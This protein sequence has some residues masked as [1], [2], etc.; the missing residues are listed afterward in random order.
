MVELFAA[1]IEAANHGAVGSILGIQGNES[2]LDLG[3]LANHP[4]PLA[5]LAGADD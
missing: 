2:S 5:I 4:A 1:E 3:K